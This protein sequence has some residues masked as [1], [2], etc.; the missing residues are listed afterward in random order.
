MV[1]MLWAICQMFAGLR[2][3]PSFA[4]AFLLNSWKIHSNRNIIFLVKVNRAENLSKTGSS[5]T[6]NSKMNCWKLSNG[7]LVSSFTHLMQLLQ[8]RHAFVLWWYSKG[9]PEGQST[10]STEVGVAL[11]LNLLLTWSS[12]KYAFLSSVRRGTK[13]MLRHV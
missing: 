7:E 4:P 12:Y 6:V 11:R 8:V 13:K 9:S 2:I 1:K 10:L 5:R 3:V